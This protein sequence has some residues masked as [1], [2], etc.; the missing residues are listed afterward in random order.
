MYFKLGGN[1]FDKFSD[2]PVSPETSPRIAV[3][4]PFEK[5]FANFFP[6]NAISFKVETNRRHE[7]SF[8]LG[9]VRRILPREGRASNGKTWDD[10][11][12]AF[13]AKTKIPVIDCCEGILT[14]SFS[15]ETTTTTTSSSSSFNSLKN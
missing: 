5:K 12:N 10:E 13:L 6:E 3:F 8:T 1:I 11:V 7:S 2:S 9:G 4:L 15:R 14:P